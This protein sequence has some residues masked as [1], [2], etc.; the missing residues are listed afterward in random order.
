MAILVP[1]KTSTLNGLKVNE[2]YDINF[3]AT[4]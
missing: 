2:Y 1:D 4:Q 3:Y